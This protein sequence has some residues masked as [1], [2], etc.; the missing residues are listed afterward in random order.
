[1]TLQRFKGLPI[2]LL[3]AIKNIITSS[4]EQRNIPDEAA[5]LYKSHETSHKSLRYILLNSALSTMMK[6]YSRLHDILLLIIIITS[7]KSMFTDTTLLLGEGFMNIQPLDLHF[8]MDKH[9]AVR[10]IHTVSINMPC[11][12]I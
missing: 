8:E 3:C 6:E 7:K 4:S 12:L 5:N 2:V 10:F 11:Y 1:M 9:T